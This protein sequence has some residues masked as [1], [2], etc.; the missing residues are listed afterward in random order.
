VFALITCLGLIL[1]VCFL[2]MC[3]RQLW[4]E[5]KLLAIETLHATRQRTPWLIHLASVASEQL[6]DSV[7]DL[8][9]LRNP[10]LLGKWVRF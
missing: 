1:L 8:V 10:G 9:H 4:V 6:V 5:S 7:N 2:V 3:G